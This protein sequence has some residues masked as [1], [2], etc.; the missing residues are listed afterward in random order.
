[1]TPGGFIS[2]ARRGAKTVRRCMC[3]GR[4]GWLVQ[5]CGSTLVRK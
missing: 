2:G 1:M 5:R 4:E 3:I